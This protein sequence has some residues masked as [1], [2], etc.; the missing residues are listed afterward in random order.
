MQGETILLSL[1]FNSIKIGADI[2]SDKKTKQRL[3]DANDLTQ[4]LIHSCKSKELN[5]ASALQCVKQAPTIIE[6][7]NTTA[8]NQ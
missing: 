7:I 5:K 2:M 6:L 3:V 4:E 8:K 1:Q